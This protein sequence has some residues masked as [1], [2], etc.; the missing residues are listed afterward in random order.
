MDALKLKDFATRY[1]AAWCSGEA[2]RVASFFAENGSLTINSGQPSVGR[3]AITEA[4]QGFMTTFPDLKVTVDAAEVR[5]SGAIFRWTA[6]GKNTGPGGTGKWVRFSGYEEWTFGSDGLVAAS[7]G[8]FDE[9]D[10]ERQLREGIG[11]H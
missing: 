11:V 9:S 5:G 3:A 4:A 8:H 2:A 6:T 1:A 10:Y 7:L